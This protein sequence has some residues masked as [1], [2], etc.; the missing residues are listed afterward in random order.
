MSKKLVN[1]QLSGS[2]CP[3]QRRSSLYSI[4]GVLLSRNK[5]NAWYDCVFYYALNKIL[6]I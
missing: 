4:T 6:N 5:Q 2:Y 3:S 1:Y